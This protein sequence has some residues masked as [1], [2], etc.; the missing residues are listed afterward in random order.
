M[1]DENFLIYGAYG[2]TGEL[3]ARLAVGRGHRPILAGR[4][5]LRLARLAAELGCQHVAFPLEDTGMMRQALG[6]VRC[7]LHCAGPFRYTAEPMARAC[8]EAGVHYLD[9][10]GEIV[11][12]EAL[13]AMDEAAQAA[14]AMLMPGVG[15]DVV[16]SDCLAAHLHRR[17]PT[18][19]HLTLVI[20]ALG[21]GISRGT[22]TSMV[23]SIG[24]ATVV[25]RDGRLV[26]LPA[27]SLRR[28]FDLGRG[29]R[30][31][32]A[33]GWG[34]VATAYRTT[35]I[36]NIEVY[37]ALPSAA[38]RGLKLVRYA[39][40]LL[41]S[42][43]ARRAL[44]AAIRR[45]PAG[46]TPEQRA[47]GSSLLWGEVV[48]AEGHR[49]A[50]RL[51]T[52]EGYTLTAETALAIAEQVLAGHATPGFQTPARVFGPDFILQFPGVQRDDISV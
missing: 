33:V 8:I 2:Y 12:I 35:G 18:A 47:R 46:P 51:R 15:F 21:G 32:V 16:P 3:I 42:A 17:L 45:A 19:T 7:V 20:R 43:P 6:H 38:V 52:P 22:A 37:F 23:E 13:A 11:A 10:T 30:E 40:P 26:T 49:A 50:A 41:A 1:S 39:A 24:S 14:G 4:D 36:P 44:K 25:R 29:P 27:G 9:I 28:Q 5:P 34:D 31:C 48:D